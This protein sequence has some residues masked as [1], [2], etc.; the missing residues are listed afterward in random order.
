MNLVF[1][2]QKCNV[3]ST[4]DSLDIQKILIHSVGLVTYITALLGRVLR[5][6][7]QPD[8]WPYHDKFIYIF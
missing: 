2:I 3:L 4:E 6:S 5:L 1:L 7:N 8:F